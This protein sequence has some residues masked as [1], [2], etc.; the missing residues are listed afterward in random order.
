MATHSSILAWRIP[1]DRG[2]WWATAHGIAESDMTEQLS[3]YWII[4]IGRVLL[5]APLE[6]Q[7]RKPAWIKSLLYARHIYNIPQ[8]SPRLYKLD[9]LIVTD[10]N[11]D[12]REDQ[13]IC[14]DKETSLA[15]QWLRL[16][17]SHSRGLG[18][19]VGGLRSHTVCEARINS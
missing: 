3:T 6:K 18:F 12:A 4:K 17:A 14:Q 7:R 13:V 1:M 15:V 19:L 9:I 8:S 11:N 10:E 2:A 16:H 5:Y